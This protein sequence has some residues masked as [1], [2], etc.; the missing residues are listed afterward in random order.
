MRNSLQTEESISDAPGLIVHYVFD[1]HFLGKE[2]CE[3]AKK[4]KHVRNLLAYFHLVRPAPSMVIH[5]NEQFAYLLGQHLI[6]SLDRVDAMIL[7]VGQ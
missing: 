5:R 1:L 2:V 6:C 3:H 4:Q 7:R